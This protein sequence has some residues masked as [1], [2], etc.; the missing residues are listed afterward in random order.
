VTFSVSNGVDVTPFRQAAAKAQAVNV[1][2]LLLQRMSLEVACAVK[3][4]RFPVGARP[5]RQPLQP[6]ATLCAPETGP[7]I[8]IRTASIAPVGKVLA[9]SASASFPAERRCAIM[10]EP[11]T[12]E[13]KGVPSASAAS[14]RDPCVPIAKALNAQ[15]CDCSRRRLDA[16]ASDPVV[17]QVFV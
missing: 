4:R 7:K 12:A 5:A 13:Q 14:H 1:T 6:V 15:H 11:T 3:R 10:P 16:N 8:K 9:R 17:R 2:V